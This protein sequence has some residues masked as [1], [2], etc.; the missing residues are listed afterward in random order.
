M[1]RKRDSGR[2]PNPPSIFEGILKLYLPQTFDLFSFKFR[3][4][5]TDCGPRSWTSKKQKVDKNVIKSW[6]D[7]KQFC[8]NLQFNADVTVFF[9]S[10][11]KLSDISIIDTTLK[12]V[13]YNLSKLTLIWNSLAL[14][15]KWKHNH[16]SVT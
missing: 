6:N 1:I 9:I 12:V 13:C 15:L 8:Q 11:Y 10:I 2:P 7:L 3:K 16:N 5:Q 14:L 4:R